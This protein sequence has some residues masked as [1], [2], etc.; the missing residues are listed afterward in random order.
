MVFFTTT[1]L[2]DGRT[3]VTSTGQLWWFFAVAIP[4]TLVVF[5]V[6]YLWRHR[7]GIKK[8]I[9]VRDLDYRGTLIGL[10]PFYPWRRRSHSQTKTGEG[11]ISPVSSSAG[12]RS[13]SNSHHHDRDEDA[14]MLREIQLVA[15]RV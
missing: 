3:Q 7:R 6:W 11:L 4:L 14:L 2:A 8:G 15:R 5:I 10:P 1:T 12:G 13:S 9:I